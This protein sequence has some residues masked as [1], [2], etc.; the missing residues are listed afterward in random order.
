MSGVTMGRRYGDSVW[1]IVCEHD[2]DNPWKSDGAIIMEQYTKLDTD[3]IQERAQGFANSGKYGRV[4]MVSFNEADCALVKPDNTPPD[5]VVE[6]L[7]AA[8]CPDSDCG[9]QGFTVVPD[10]AGEATQQQCQW[11][12][13]RQKILDDDASKLPF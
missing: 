9:G 13:E 11:C 1:L 7:R 8:Q 5:H 12:A 2:T 6:L 3:T 10:G 4:W